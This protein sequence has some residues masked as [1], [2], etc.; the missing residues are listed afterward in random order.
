M[1]DTLILLLPITLYLVFFRMCAVMSEVCFVFSGTAMNEFEL[2]SVI[3]FWP[4]VENVLSCTEL[5]AYVRNDS[6]YW[7]VLL[8][9]LLQLIQWKVTK[10]RKLWESGRNRYIQLVVSS[11]RTSLSNV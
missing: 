6:I 1:K 10:S 3:Y 9:N 4:S 11:E 2:K 7:H 5:W 8:L